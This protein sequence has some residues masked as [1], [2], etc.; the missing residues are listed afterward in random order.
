M[1]KDEQIDLIILLATFRS[2]NEQL[3]NLK[4]KHSGPTKRWFNRLVNTANSYEKS[5]KRNDDKNLEIVYDSITDL[6]Y[7]IRDGVNK[8]EEEPCV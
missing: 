5:L 1:N 6:I 3:Y 4:G 7:S 8:T 2:F